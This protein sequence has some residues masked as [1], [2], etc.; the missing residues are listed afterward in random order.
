MNSHKHA[1]L[2]F[3]RRIEMIREMTVDG[4]NAS[5]AASRHGVTPRSRNSSA[6][7]R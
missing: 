3:V 4:L 7:A 2:T 1:R 6:G 5:Q